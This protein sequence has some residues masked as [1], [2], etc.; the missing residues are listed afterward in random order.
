MSTK[1]FFGHPSGLATLFFTEMW[2][3]FSYYGMRALLILFM[4]TP[5]L[6]G[7]LEFDDVTSGAIYGLYTMGVYLLA[8][9]GGWLADHIIGLK[10]SVWYGGIIITL[11]HF[12][13]AIPGIVGLFGMH[14]EGVTG[15]DTNSFFL[16]LILIAV[17]T[18]MLK[19]NVSSIV[20]ELYGGAEDKDSAK[21][22]AGFS[23][24]YMGINI[25]ALLAPIVCSFLAAEV[26]WHLGFGAAGIGMLLGLI[27]YKATASNLDGYGDAPVYETPE[28]QAKAAKTANIAKI[29]GCVALVIFALFF[30]NVISIDA[31]SIANAS[32]YIISA[33]AVLFFGYV[34]LLGGL[35]I[36][37]KKKVGVIGLLLIFS[38]LFWSGFE[39]AGSTL[40]LF[41]E[42]FTDRTVF[43]WEIPAGMFQSI[44]SM[45]IIIFAPIFGAMWVWLAKKNLEPSSPLKFAFGLILLGIGFLVMYFAAKIAASG[46]LAAPTWLIFTYLFHTFGELSL[47]PVGLS[48][49]TKL[50]PHR[51]AGQMMGMWFLSIAM[52]NL[53]AG[54]I[55]GSLSGGTEDTLAS[56]PSQYMLIVYTTV[57]AGILLLLISKPVRKLMGNVH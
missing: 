54:L 55:A 36:E 50:S 49:V 45:F 30:F 22:D 4:T 29:V 40:N 31:V 3:R 28:E 48:L 9:P 14:T 38:A 15:L 41:A 23:I 17:G 46:D 37:E 6:S 16:G 42:R 10:K 26:D 51:Y 11:G 20:G 44:N 8:L 2:E 19:P 57:G 43:G 32:K 47:S 25:G 52:G 24:F 33:A 7:G 53:F 27:Q 13:M 12:T 5:A 1:T 34:I 39:Q 21:R 35:N 18:G 56:M